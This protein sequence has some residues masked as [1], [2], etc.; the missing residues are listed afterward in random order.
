VPKV[1]DR[2]CPKVLVL[3]CLLLALPACASSSS[4]YPTRSKL[5]GS[6]SSYRFLVLTDTRTGVVG[7]SFPD[8]NAPGAFCAIADGSGGWYIG[9]GFTRVGEVSRPRLA[10]LKSDGGLDRGFAPELPGS[11]WVGSVLR[12]GGTVYAGV[13]FNVVALDARNGKQLWRTATQRGGVDDLGFKDGVLYVSGSFNRIGGTS[14]DGLAA[15]D[16]RTGRVTSWRIRLSNRGSSAVV[17]PLAFSGEVL[18]VGGDFDRIDGSRRELGLAAIDTRTARPTAWAPIPKAG[19]YDPDSPIA[20]VI[21]HGQVIVGG[22]K[23]GFASY[24]VRTARHL[25]WPLRYSGS[26][27]APLAVLAD[28]VYLSAGPGKDNNP[29]A[30]VLPRGSLASW[31]PKLG[32]GASAIAISGGKILVAGA[33]PA[34]A[35]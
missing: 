32:S 20:I 27:G 14:R 23:S 26:L 35:G 19:Y 11:D 15:L 3:A 13:G 24:D 10:H 1:G 34:K 17:G 18:Y 2:I 9:G 30:V 7:R 31:R 6:G 28:T 21:S 29:A 5:S 16:P 33:F 4:T 12:R 8:V 22:S 25:G